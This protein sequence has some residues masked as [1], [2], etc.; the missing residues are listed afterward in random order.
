MDL[1]SFYKILFVILFTSVV[2]WYLVS[3]LNE[4]SERLAYFNNI[5]LEEEVSDH[6][7]DDQKE[8]QDKDSSRSF[9]EGDFYYS[10]KRLEKSEEVTSKPLESLSRS[11]D[12]ESSLSVD[13]VVFYSNQERAEEG[14]HSLIINEKLNLAAEKKMDDMFDSQYFAHND[15]DGGMG[16]GFLAEKVDYEYITVGENLAMGNFKDDSDLVQSWMDSPGHRLNIIKEDYSEI[17]VAVGKGEFEGRNVW[18]AVQIFGRPLSDCS[19]IDQDLKIKINNNDEVLGVLKREIDTLKEKIEEGNFSSQ[20]EYQEVL[21][22]YNSIIE[23]YNELLE[24]TKLLIERF[25][26]QVEI[27]N[28]CVEG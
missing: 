17:G 10:D 5:F 6:Y 11:S 19:D 28:K 13:G 8:E 16:A 18:M 2:S 7:G 27:F 26:T 22:Q 4:H 3:V 23:E 21:V 12:P 24:E 14:V 1:R 9:G 25:N 20:E 15:P